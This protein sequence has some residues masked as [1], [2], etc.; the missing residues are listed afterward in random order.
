VGEEIKRIQGEVN[1][2]EA[3]VVE[4]TSQID[5]ADLS[6]TFADGM[7]TYLNRMTEAKPGAW[8]QK[9]I[10]VMF[11]D[12]SFAF[13][14]GTSTWSTKLGGT[15][16][17]YF[18]LSYHYALLSL[19]KDPSYNYPGLA[20]IDLPAEMLDGSSVADKENFVMIP[21]VELL[22]E[23]VMKGTQLIAAGSAFQGLNGAHRIELTEIWK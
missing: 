23:D 6:D 7:N 12:R 21:F 8:M 22:K 5:F 11:S 3:T 2:L 1:R 19:T 13:K 4:K 16:T 10:N 17:L 15:L 9:A 14:V 18:L 20:L